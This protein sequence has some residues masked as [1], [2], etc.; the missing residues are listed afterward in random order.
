MDGGRTASG[1]GRAADEVKSI[2]PRVEV[3]YPRWKD[4]G[5]RERRA[6]A[7]VPAN[8]TQVFHVAGR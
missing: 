2:L 5:Q 1:V 6:I 3:V 8:G 4:R 7:F